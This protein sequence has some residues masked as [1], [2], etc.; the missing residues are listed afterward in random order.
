MATKASEYLRKKA[1]AVL[2]DLFFSEADIIEIPEE[3]RFFLSVEE[4]IDSSGFMVIE[5]V[6]EDGYVAYIC[7]K[8]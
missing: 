1:L 5:K 7:Q 6:E 4:P 3:D 8:K 2:P